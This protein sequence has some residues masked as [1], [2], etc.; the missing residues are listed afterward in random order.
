LALSFA[1]EVEIH[2]SD[3][4]T[5]V[6]ARLSERQAQAELRAEFANGEQVS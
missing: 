3:F 1:S 4:N 6:F 2:P 5:L